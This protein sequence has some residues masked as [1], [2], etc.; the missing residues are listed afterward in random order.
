MANQGLLQLVDN[1]RGLAY[2]R[3]GGGPSDNNYDPELLSIML[4][5]AEEIE[6]LCNELERKP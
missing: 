2:L 4:I 3:A 6:Q 1:I 5:A